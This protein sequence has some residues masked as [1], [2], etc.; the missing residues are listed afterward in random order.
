M[1]G[2]TFA[3]WASVSASLVL[4]ASIWALTCS[5]IAGLCALVTI[6]AKTT[7]APT[8]IS[9]GL[10]VIM[11]HLRASIRRDAAS[12]EGSNIE[13]GVRPMPGTAESLVVAR[14]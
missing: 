1:I 4:A 7:N 9:R 14:Y 10:P 11:M 12:L 6:D 2:S 5:F 13:S 3:R 8:L